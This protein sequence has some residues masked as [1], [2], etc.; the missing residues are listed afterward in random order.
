MMITSVSELLALPEFGRDRYL[1]LA[2]Y[3]AALPRGTTLNVCTANPQIIDAMLSRLSDVSDFSNG[4][5]QQAEAR[6]TACVAQLATSHRSRA[7]VCIG[8][9]RKADG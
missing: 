3:V 1:K 5:E 9:A 8:P 2:P 7:L 6:K 4:G